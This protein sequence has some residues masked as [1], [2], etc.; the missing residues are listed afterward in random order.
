M[1]AKQS[2]SLDENIMDPPHFF[3][4]QILK[5]PVEIS[6]EHA[7]IHECYVDIIVICQDGRKLPYNAA[8]FTILNPQLKDAVQSVYQDS[9]D[10]NIIVDSSSFEEITLKMKSIFVSS[11]T[12]ASADKCEFTSVPV[13]EEEGDRDD[14]LLQY[15]CES[16]NDNIQEIEVVEEYFEDREGNQVIEVKLDVINEQ[17]LELGPLLPS[18]VK[19]SYQCQ[20]CGI[21]LKSKTSLDSHYYAKHYKSPLSFSCEIC[22]K[23]FQMQSR[24]MKHQ[25]CHTQ[26]KSFKCNKDQCVKSFKR[27]ADLKAHIKQKHTTLSGDLNCK[28]CD[29]TFTQR[30]GLNRH[31][32]SIHDNDSQIFKCD[33]CSKLYKR[34]DK[35][36]RHMKVCH[37]N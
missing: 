20:F 24:L 31:I 14:N 30:S 1:Y 35:L 3:L 37:V 11:S 28:L 27:L 26:F 22:N 29:K 21:I 36:T 19:E 4:Q 7:N 13:E 34:K 17:S 32:K 18:R 2:E 12:T 9:V 8:L 15:D 33:L 6:D 10:I 23:T 25:L 5:T 16:K